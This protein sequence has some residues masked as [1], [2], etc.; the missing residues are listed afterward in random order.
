MWCHHS[1]VWLCNI[2]RLHCSLR[3]GQNF[4]HWVHTFRVPIG[5]GPVFAG[6]VQ[7]LAAYWAQDWPANPSFCRKTRRCTAL[8]PGKIERV[9]DRPFRA[10]WRPLSLTFLQVFRP[11]LPCSQ[12]GI[13]RPASQ[14][15]RQPRRLLLFGGVFL[16]GLSDHVVQFALNLGGVALLFA[17]DGAPY[18]GTSAGVA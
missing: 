17:G 2:A 14:R 11:S 16:K 12:T 5:D 10:R 3:A 1:S 6:R 9:S 8:S 15:A 13:R 18:Q 7:R 4:G